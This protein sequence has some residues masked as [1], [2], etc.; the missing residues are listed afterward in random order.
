MSEMK[1]GRLFKLKRVTA[2]VLAAL[3]ITVTLP[4][5]VQAK[6]HSSVPAESLSIYLNAGG[7]TELLHTYTLQEMTNLMDG[8]NVK[9]SSIDAMPARVLTVGSGVYLNTL[10]SDLGKLAGKELTDF[11]TLKFT[12]TDGWTR[13]YTKAQ[14]FQTKYYYKDLFRTETWNSTKGTVDESAA[15]SGAEVK[16]MLAVYSWQ[17]RVLD[18]IDDEAALTGELTSET[19]FRLCFGMTQEDLTSGESTTSEYG[20]W[21]NQIEITAG[22]DTLPQSAEWD[23]HFEDVKESDWFYDAVKFASENNLFQGSGENSF[24]PGGTM[25]RAMFVTVLGRLA[26]A[27]TKKYSSEFG[28]VE[29]DQYYAGYVAWASING[30]VNGSGDG[31]FRP[32]DKITREQLA[33]ILYRFARQSGADV[34]NTNVAKAAAYPDFEIVMGAAKP[35]VCWAVNEGILN[36]SN[37]KLEPKGQASRAQVAQ[38]IKNFAGNGGSK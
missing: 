20:K 18:R 27:D 14:L 2:I 9:Y 13:T 34:S 11:E 23:S 1:M 26:Q 16:P 21:I 22:G 33:L 30:I 3:L 10:I 24:S 25:T 36:G 37:G 15:R 35:A 12:A 19:V 29:K 5:Q 4:C 31:T 28:D 17:G 8:K 32:D 6:T 7:K 38:M